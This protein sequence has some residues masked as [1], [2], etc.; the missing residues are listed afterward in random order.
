MAKKKVEEPQEIKD[1]NHKGETDEE[2]DS[3]ERAETGVF[4][5]IDIDARY[6]ID[7][8]KEKGIKVS[9]II[10]DAI[11][12]YDLYRSL[13]PEIRAIMD[14]HAPKEIESE[15][16]NP[17]FAKHFQVIEEAVKNLGQP[18][19]PE[20]KDDMALWCRARD[21]GMM[22]IGKLTF[23]QLL[24]AASEKRDS[25]D[26]PQKKNNGLDVIL[27]YLGPGKTIKN[28]SLKEI[29]HA[30]QRMWT[31]SNYFDIIELSEEN[32]DTYYL[33]FIHQQNLDYS[34]Y[35]LGYFQI[36]FDSLH[37]N[38][39]VPFECAFEGNTSEQTVYITIKELYAKSNVKSN[40]Q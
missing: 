8:Y 20:K 18:Q 33:T 29:V 22:L 26:K 28:V 4:A 36:L 13:P 6:I 1:L 11:D 32:G 23:N 2:E 39:D 17:E 27:W 10:E 9:T 38:P 31:V 37:G 35:W 15:R 5:K 12:L 14:Q 24:A 7:K 25:L 3:I 30:I 19:S 16:L 21:R 34:N 40:S